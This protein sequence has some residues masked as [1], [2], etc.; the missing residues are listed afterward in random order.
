MKDNRK[1]AGAAKPYM[2]GAPTDENTVRNSLVFFG[3]LILA[4]FMCFIVCSMTSFKS[5]ILRVLVNVIIEAL[6]L[7]IFYAK[8]AEYGT[9]GVSRGEILYQHIQKGQEVSAGEKSVPFHPLKGFVVGALGTL[10][11]LIL[12]VILAFSAE[13]QMTNAGVLPSWM[14]TYLRRSE[15]GDAL[16]GYTQSIPIN[17]TDIVRI[18]VRIMMMPLVTMAGAEN[19]DLLLILER[20][21]PLI[22][23][24]PAASYG[25][26]YLTGPSKRR[27]IHK[28]IADNN[29]KRISRERRA[30][31][32]RRNPVARTPEQLN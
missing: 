8:G 27:T 15:I 11:P 4:G 16:A 23:L 9:D 2:T 3:V 5:V 13:R 12:A 10:I 28:E 26:G 20:I 25:I 22:V 18:A 21:S 19:R 7:V 29:R 6:I 1:T 31:K 32:A 24:F 17:A 30:R 14:E